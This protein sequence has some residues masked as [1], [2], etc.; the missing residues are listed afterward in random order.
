VQYTSG[1]GKAGGTMMTGWRGTLL[2]EWTLLSTITA[3]TGLPET[4]I[5]FATTPGTSETGYIRPNLTGAPIY[6][7]A[8]AG[9]HLNIGAYTA[10]PSGQW[11]DARRDSITGPG[12][13]TLNGTLQRT[14]RFK[15]N[16]NLDFTVAATN[17]LNHV[18]YSTWNTIIPESSVDT[19]TFGLPASANAMRSLQTTIRLRY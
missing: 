19:T 13:F 14:F 1:M 12:Q 11:G 4:P 16:L 5:F 18:V 17:L 8:A 2:K 15:N 10:P 3:G 9:R 6:S 7:G